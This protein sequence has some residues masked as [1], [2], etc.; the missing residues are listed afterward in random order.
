MRIMID[1][2]VFP[3]VSTE[4]HKELRNTRISESPNM[5]D[6]FGFG[7]PA[8]PGAIYHGFHMEEKR[9][10]ES[11]LVGHEQGSIWSQTTNVGL[12]LK[13]RG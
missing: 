3:C 4:D 11:L 7:V 2:H 1:N 10:G 8:K 12:R 5:M 6:S 9:E 13:F